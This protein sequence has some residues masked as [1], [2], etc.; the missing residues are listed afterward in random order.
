MYSNKTNNLFQPAF[1]S[2]GILTLRAYSSATDRRGHYFIPCSPL[3]PCASLYP[4]PYVSWIMSDSGTVAS[5]IFSPPYF[6]CPTSSKSLQ[7]KNKSVS[8][9]LDGFHGKCPWSLWIITSPSQSL[10]SPPFHPVLTVG[11]CTTSSWS[12]NGSWGRLSE[13]G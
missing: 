9:K 5:W 2:S 12:K 8:D 10:T 4:S 1:C 7:L 13:T 3:Y 11:H 6:M